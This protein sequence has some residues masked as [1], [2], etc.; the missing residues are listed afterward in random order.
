VNTAYSEQK[1]LVYKLQSGNY[2]PHTFAVGIQCAEMASEIRSHTGMR[3]P[4]PTPW[5]LP[6]IYKGPK[7]GLIFIQPEDSNC[8]LYQTISK[9]SFLDAA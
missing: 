3:L 6:D 5:P 7:M 2:S 9:S 8:S 4:P 1:L